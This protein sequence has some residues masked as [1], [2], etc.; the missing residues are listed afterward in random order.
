MSETLPSACRP[1]KLPLSVVKD[2]GIAVVALLVLA[3][4]PRTGFAQAE[5]DVPAEV[6]MGNYVYLEPSESRVEFLLPLG[7]LKGLLKPE[8]IS[9]GD[10]SDPMLDGEARKSLLPELTELLRKACRIQ[11]DGSPVDFQISQIGFVVIDPELGP[12]PDE[13]P[14]IKASDGLI[15]AIFVAPTRGFPDQLDIDWLLFPDTMTEVE[16]AVEALSSPDRRDPDFSQV[17][18]IT[19]ESPSR[20]LSL[21]EIGPDIGLREV[22]AVVRKPNQSIGLVPW[23]FLAACVI[24]LGIG[25]RPRAGDRIPVLIA[26]GVAAVF[27][28]GAFSQARKVSTVEIP[29]GENA[30]ALVEVLLSNVYQAFSYRDENE[31]Y[32]V[33]EESIKGSL[34]DQV[35]SDI[36]RGVKA[37]ED[38]GP[39]VRV[40]DVIVI[41]CLVQRDGDQGGL[42]T[43]IAW[44]CY[45]NVS[46]WGHKHTRRNKYR[47]TLKI[48]PVDDQWKIIGM[49]ILEEDRLQ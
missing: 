37:A 39:T 2:V 8:E 14:S 13:R 34:L 38:G 18:R 28:G 45:G 25:L 44:E 32:D 27:A 29:D 42:S 17:L 21:P 24:L 1:Y 15:A 11:F 20:S 40:L 10:S 49:D 48:E 3:L 22:P 4:F 12:I 6:K 23:L 36:W 7:L 35:Y 5:E 33:L 26:A 30:G 46:H 16:V 43:A 19:R 31:I 47:A 9:V 41:D